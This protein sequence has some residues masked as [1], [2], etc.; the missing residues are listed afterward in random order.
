MSSAS[1][2]SPST[3]RGCYGSCGH[4]APP[5]ATQLRLISPKWG[6]EPYGTIGLSYSGHQGL[7]AS[8]SARFVDKCNWAAR[9]Y[10]SS[11]TIHASAGYGLNNHVEVNVVATDLLDQK[12]YQLYGGSVIGRRVLGGMTAT[13]E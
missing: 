8:V 9:V 3:L 1:C 5:A 4:A 11:Q 10:P 6:V 12:R 2:S 7:E 13:L